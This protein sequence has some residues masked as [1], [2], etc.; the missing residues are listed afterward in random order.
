[1][2]DRLKLCFL[3]GS[4]ATGGAE[5]QLVHLLKGLDGNHFHPLLVTFEG[6]RFLP[7]I[8]DAGIEHV[9][10]PRSGGGTVTRAV[11]GMMALCDILSGFKPDVL[12]LQLPGTIIA[13]SLAGA[14]TNM[15]RIVISERGLGRTRPAWERPARRLCYR[16]A[17]V[18]AT[19]S[20]ATMDR[21]LLED[22]VE[23]Y[24]LRLIPNGVELPALTG[25]RGPDTM[26]PV[27][28]SLGRLDPVKGY[29]VLIRAFQLVRNR[30]PGARMVIFGEGP[31]R[32]DLLNLAA[33][34]GV[35]DAVSLPGIT[36]NIY[37]SLGEMDLFVSAS[38]FEGLSNAMME[39]MSAGL[40]VVGTAVGGTPSLLRGGRAGALVEP[41]DPRSLADGICGLL[42]DRV[43][44]DEMGA[45]ARRVVE[46]EYSIGRMI[47]SWTGLYLS[48]AD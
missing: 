18:I 20:P 34:L 37:G 26:D 40:P 3:T 7:E 5:V 33:E 39:A 48:L 28:G 47:A 9:I 12:H 43:R 19:N 2:A 17:D 8:L 44:M 23:E 15:P 30:I 36:G 42:G 1:M 24:K 10:L 35:E 45:M 16:L 29:D 14:L 22:G 13:G 6:G 4:L 41:D 25:R 38:R 32:S 21:L 11:S 46:E 27:V 31:T